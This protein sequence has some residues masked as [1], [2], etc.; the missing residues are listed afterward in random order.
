MKTLEFEKHFYSRR[1]SELEEKGKLDDSEI[2]E[3][4]TMLQIIVANQ[5]YYPSQHQAMLEIDAYVRLKALLSANGAEELPE[6]SEATH[7]TP[8]FDAEQ[9]LDTFLDTICKNITVTD[10][11]KDDALLNEIC[12]FSNWVSQKDGTKVY[13]LRDM[14]LP[15]LVQREANGD[16]VAQPFLFGRKLLKFFSDRTALDGFDFGESDDADIYLEFLYII[17]D[18]ADAYPNDFEKFFEYVRPRFLEKIKSMPEYYNF[19][20]NYLDNIKGDKILVVES[21]IMGTMPL[22]LKSIDPRVDFVLFGTTPA[23]Y[24]IYGERVFTREMSKLMDLE[25]SVSQNELFVFS[26]VKDGEVYIKQ[27]T[28]IERKQASLDEINKTLA[29]YKFK[30]KK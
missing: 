9:S 16:R 14:F 7:E 8:N 25:Q 1:I 11:T 22:I 24:H 3:A 12:A 27:T 20:K 13:L 2:H 6:I 19:I 28:D 23:F 10:F 29:L 15:Y 21:G 5:N 26:S 17:Y 30:Y 4:Q 18:G